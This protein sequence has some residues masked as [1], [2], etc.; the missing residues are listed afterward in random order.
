[1][2]RLASWDW[3]LTRAPF[4]DPCPPPSG[5]SND[6]PPPPNASQCAT[7]RGTPRCTQLFKRWR[8]HCQAPTVPQKNVLLSALQQLLYNARRSTQ[9]VQAPKSFNTNMNS[10]QNFEY[11]EYKHIV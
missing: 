6:S 5:G 9:R 3:P 8:G 7:S 11:F 4:T 10:L 2:R 1:M